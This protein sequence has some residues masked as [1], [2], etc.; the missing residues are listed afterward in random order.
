MPSDANK[1][2]LEHCLEF[3]LSTVLV[4]CLGVIAAEFL[5]FLW[6]VQQEF[7]HISAISFGDIA[8]FTCVCLMS[9]VPLV[10]LVI[11]R[12]SLAKAVAAWQLQAAERLHGSNSIAVSRACVALADCLTET[13]DYDKAQSLYKRAIAINA[14]SGHSSNSR[15]NIHTELRYLNFLR[16]SD[17]FAG[18]AEITPFLLELEKRYSLY[19]FTGRILYRVALVFAFL[20]T[21]ILMLDWMAATST[22][23]GNYDLAKEIC[24]LTPAPP[25][26]LSNFR[27]GNSLETLARGYSKGSQWSK[28][29]PLYSTLLEIREVKEGANSPAAAE[30]MQLLSEAY[31]NQG[32][33]QNAQHLLEKALQIYKDGQGVDDPRIA[34]VLNDLATVYCTKD[35]FDQSK[36][37]LQRALSMYE[38][39]R[40]SRQPG[41]VDSL[42]RLALVLSTKGKYEQAEPLYK[43]ALAVSEENYGAND[44][45]LAQTLDD[46]AS[47]LKKIG[48]KNEAVKLE[49]RARAIRAQHS[50]YTKR[51]ADKIA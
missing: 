2:R 12:R 47:L 37:I 22:L 51:R 28:A 31:L 15:F 14:R 43:L 1:N 48:H 13:G 38:K 46:Y 10:T 27:V 45:R 6:I 34:I 8:F 26:I 9:L 41:V 25:P 18:A 30:M 39:H 50:S 29:V 19:K 42:H 4:L 20:S 24:R 36:E 3:F 5:F 17:R 21:S 33:Y 7:G 40:N 49:S 23:A 11:G 35:R 44:A 16:Q 32:K